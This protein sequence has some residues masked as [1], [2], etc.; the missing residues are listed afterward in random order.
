MNFSQPLPIG[1]L[2]AGNVH[3]D[4]NSS[5]YNSYFDPNDSYNNSLGLGS[6]PVALGLSPVM[7]DASMGHTPSIQGSLSTG[8]TPAYSPEDSS[9]FNFNSQPTTNGCVSMPPPLN[10]ILPTQYSDRN[11]TGNGY[12]D[13]RGLVKRDPDQLVPQPFFDD[14]DDPL[15]IEFVV[16]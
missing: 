5:V 2:L 15:F 1:G 11:G 4:S 9:P 10:P 6:Q 16:E 8:P 7:T 3:S 12:G 14:P 13:I